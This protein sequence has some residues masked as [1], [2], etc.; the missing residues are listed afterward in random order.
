MV[1]LCST[2][3]CWLLMRIGIDG[4]LLAEPT[5]GIGRYTV[6]LSAELVK[7]P[8]EF[9]L[10]SPRPIINGQWKNDNITIRTANLHSRAQRMFWSQTSLPY[11]AVK[12]HVDIFWGPTHRLPRFLPAG[13]A[14]VVTIHD[15]VWKYA[16]KTM[17][18]LSHWVEKRL[19]P[20]AIHQADRIVAVSVSTGK[21]H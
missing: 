5:T 9:F 10:Y 11:W 20:Q 18:P 1:R 8:G 15:L 14:R 17:R 4:R 7:M 21:G 13:T 16:G 6:E 12:D 3:E 2:Y 19:M